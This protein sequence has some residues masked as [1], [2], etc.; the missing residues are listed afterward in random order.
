[1]NYVLT[2]NYY[3]SKEICSGACRDIEADTDQKCQFW[4]M[5]LNSGGNVKLISCDQSQPCFSSCSELVQ[6]RFSTTVVESL[7]I[8]GLEVTEVVRVENRL[9]FNGYVFI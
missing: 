4:M 5:E 7:G 3:R 6:S 1:M 9:L 2:L 8:T